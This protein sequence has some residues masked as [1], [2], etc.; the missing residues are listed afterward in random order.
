M[1]RG[2]GSPR[3]MPGFVAPRAAVS[4]RGGKITYAN[5]S[6]FNA[7]LPIGT[8]AGDVLIIS[9][10]HGYQLSTISGGT[11]LN[12]PG[13]GGNG[14]KIATTTD[15]ANGYVAVTFGG[16]YYGEVSVVSVMNAPNIVTPIR[17]SAGVRVTGTNVNVST[18]GTTPTAGDVIIYWTG[19]RR[20]GNSGQTF[21]MPGT[22]LD[23]RT[24]DAN[25]SGY[26]STG[27][28]SAAPVTFSGTWS[29]RD[30]NDQ[31]DGIVVVKS[32]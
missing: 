5:S 2:N 18:S 25:Y 15:V 23:S 9:A 14:W 32:T 10:S 21:T 22:V 8:A 12:T 13:G 16:G 17:V 3:G 30:I 26:V 4:V 24:A 20:D 27:R 28:A 29:N 1:P 7:A 6:L 31:F 11:V 19:S